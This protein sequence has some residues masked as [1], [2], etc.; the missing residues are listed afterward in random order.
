[1]STSKCPGTGKTIYK[2]SGE[3]K[4]VML[5]IQG[6]SKFNKHG[7][8][9]HHR[10]GKFTARRFYHCPICRGFHLTSQPVRLTP[11]VITKQYK[12]R[13]RDTSHLVVPWEERDKWKTGSLPFPE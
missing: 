11:K 6:S 13:I 12:Q 8:R 10:Q 2:T 9:V 3:A 7:R 1:M 4:E 5:R